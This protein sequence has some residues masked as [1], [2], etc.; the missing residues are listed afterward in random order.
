M[1]VAQNGV[2]NTVEEREKSFQKPLDS[3]IQ[4]RK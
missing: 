1:V 2:K 3:Y 4:K